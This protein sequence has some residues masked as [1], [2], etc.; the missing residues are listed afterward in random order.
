MKMQTNEL[1]VCRAPFAAGFVNVL[2]WPCRSV[3]HCSRGSSVMVPGFLRGTRFLREV[4]P[5]T[6]RSVAEIMR[7][8]SSSSASASG[9]STPF[10]RRNW[11]SARCPA[12]SSASATG[13]TPAWSTCKVGCGASAPSAGSLA[14]PGGTGSFWRASRRYRGRVLLRAF[15]LR[16]HQ[17]QVRLLRRAFLLQRHHLHKREVPGRR[18]LRRAFP[19]MRGMRPTASR[20]QAGTLRRT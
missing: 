17:L 6:V 12:S 5:L 8:A 10:W 1:L 3:P 20:G 16:R 7:A 14:R 13:R 4:F 9:C 19:P 15:R 2:D 18:R 11:P